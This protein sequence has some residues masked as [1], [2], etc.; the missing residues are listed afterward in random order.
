MKGKTFDK[1]FNTFIVAGMVLATVLITVFEYGKSP[2][3]NL[4]LLV[5]AAGSI[6]GVLC[7]VLSANGNILTFLFGFFDVTIYAVMCFIGARYGNALLYALFFV[8]MQFVGF[9]QWK[10]RGVSGENLT[11]ARRF[12]LKRSILYSL[13]FLV[14][15]I[16]AYIILAKVDKETADSF[17][18]VAVLFDALSMI[19]NLLGQVLMTFAYMEQWIFWIAVN[20]F[21]IAMWAVSLDGAADSYALVLVVKYTFYLL[22]SLNGLRIWIGL[23]KKE[24]VL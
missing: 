21:T 3:G 5:T 24:E 6:M 4:L 11:T 20:V 16:V 23:S 14:G 17:I 13:L 12:D 15:S 19:C 8:P 9:V 22:N 1:W 18:K 7:T 10:K 2:D